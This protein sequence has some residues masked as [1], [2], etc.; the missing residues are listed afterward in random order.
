MIDAFVS[1]TKSMGG[2]RT[3]IEMPCSFAAVELLRKLTDELTT[4]Y[5]CGEILG[6]EISNIPND[7]DEDE[8]GD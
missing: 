8:E 1:V 6:F 4:K 5:A 7:E 3:R 2:V